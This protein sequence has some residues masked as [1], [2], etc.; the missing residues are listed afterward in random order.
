MLCSPDVMAFLHSVFRIC[1]RLEN[2]IRFIDYFTKWVNEFR[3]RSHYY[4]LY[5]HHTCFPFT[6]R[7]DSTKLSQIKL[8]LLIFFYFLFSLKRIL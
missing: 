6:V 1:N 3:G 5:I 8:L 2:N 7:H 4:I